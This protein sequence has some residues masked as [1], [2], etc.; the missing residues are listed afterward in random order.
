MP[1]IGFLIP[2]IYKKNH[3]IFIPAIGDGVFDQEQGSMIKHHLMNAASGTLGVKNDDPCNSPRPLC[4]DENPK[5]SVT[6]CR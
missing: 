2:D 6:V 4:K 5:K 1:G 3:G